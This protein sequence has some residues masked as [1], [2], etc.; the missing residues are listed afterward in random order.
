MAGEDKKRE[1]HIDTQ[2][3][4]KTLLRPTK[5]ANI[6]ILFLSKPIILLQKNRCFHL[7]YFQNIN[8]HPPYYFTKK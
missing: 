7:F 3:C 1:R 4:K 5:L 8:P 6:I 2:T